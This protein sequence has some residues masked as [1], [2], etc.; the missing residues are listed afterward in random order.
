MTLLVITQVVDRD[1]PVLGFFHQWIEELAATVDAIEVL[2]LREGMHAL[3]G[4]VK[5][6]SLGKERGERTPLVYAIRFLQ[7]LWRI[8]GTYQAVFVHMNQEYL[9]IAGWFWKIA[10]IPAYLW[11]NHVQGDWRTTLAC[12]LAHTV[13][14]TSSHAFVARRKNA[15][16]MPIGIDTDMFSGQGKRIPNTILFLGRLD[17]IKRLDL[18]LEAIALLASRGTEARLSVYGAPSPGQEQYAVN[19]RA[20]YKHL[21]DRGIVTYEGPLSHAETP[22]VY[23]RHSVYVNVT[24]SGSFDKT[25]GEAMA[26]GCLVVCA[27]EAVREALP[28]RFFIAD[29][30]SSAVADAL[31]AALTTR[32]DEQIA[33]R[34]MARGHI[35]DAHSLARLS[36]ELTRQIVQ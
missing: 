27:N 13:F 7:I 20:R 15:V 6:H 2:C 17:T 30:S 8:R 11:R 22:G 25:I 9:L 33:A 12:M 10:G 28:K 3:P 36:R 23:A 29:D 4:N 5:V 35:V 31:A 26:S 32:E 16:Q 1:D 21:E 24:P 18:V 14:Y 34:E 19:V